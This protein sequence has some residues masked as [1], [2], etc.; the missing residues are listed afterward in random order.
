MDKINYTIVI[1]SILS[2]VEMFVNKEMSTGITLFVL[3]GLYKLAIAP[4]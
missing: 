4:L 2:C 1:I 3:Y